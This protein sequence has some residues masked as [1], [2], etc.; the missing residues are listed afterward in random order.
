MVTLSPGEAIDGNGRPIIVG[1]PYHFCFNDLITAHKAR[2]MVV[3]VATH[4]FMPCICVNPDPTAPRDPGAAIRPGPYLLCIE[5]EETP[6]GEAARYG[7]LCGHERA[8]H[9]EA[10]GWRGGFGLSLA[11]FPVALPGAEEIRT[12]WDLRGVLSA[13]YYNVFEH[14]LIKRWD[15]P[16]AVD[17]GFCDPTGPMEHVSGCVPLAMV[18]V[19]HDGSLV[20]LDSWIPR[21]PLAATAAQSSS[22]VTIGAPADAACFARIHQFQCMLAQ[23]LRVA[24]V[25]VTPP[26]KPLYFNLYDRG[27]RNIPPVGFLPVQPI[28][29]RQ[30]RE[31]ADSHDA[32][33]ALSGLMTA[34]PHAALVFGTIL[35]ADRYFKGTTVF[36][37]YVVAL[38][39]DDILEDVGNAFAKDPIVVRSLRKTWIDRISVEVVAD[40]AEAAGAAAPAESSDMGARYVEVV[41]AMNI[42]SAYSPFTVFVRLLGSKVWALV[43]H[44]DAIINRQLEVVKVIVPLQGVRRP[45]PVVGETETDAMTSLRE[46]AANTFGIDLGTVSSEELAREASYS[47]PRHFVCYVKQRVVLLDVLYLMLSLLTLTRRRVPMA[48]A[49]IDKVMAMQP[50]ESEE[51][52]DFALVRKALR[53]TSSEDRAMIAAAASLP[54]VRR[55]LTEAVHLAAPGIAR[56]GV[57]ERFRGRIDERAKELEAAGTASEAAR[58]RAVEEI[59][60]AYALEVPAFEPIAALALVLD[61]DSMDAMLRDVQTIST[62]DIAVAV[63]TGD[64][65]IADLELEKVAPAVFTDDR[66]KLF[67]ASLRSGLTGRKAADFVP[68]LESDITVGRVL[69]L[70]E[71]KAVDLLGGKDKLAAFLRK[72]RP[73]LKAVRTGAADLASL[74]PSDA[75]KERYTALVEAGSKPS[76]AFDAVMAEFATSTEDGKLIGTLKSALKATGE[77]DRTGLAG[78]LFRAGK[79]RPRVP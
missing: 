45:H 6:Q 17:N 49:T 41:R 60:E 21:R 12:E 67:Y 40:T 23:S 24:P 33:G 26:A 66:G 58:T 56:E 19:A 14:N 53:E 59:S 39:D 77:G 79:F 73:A 4:R 76:D 32:I 8:I 15:K 11:Y 52:V 55:V 29:V 31:G 64:Q 34:S 50:L 68:G 5:P 42:S 3:G 20:F 65:S 35:A 38:H 27:F 63:P 2:P 51:P 7:E 37:Y 46:L 30:I 16:F 78:V 69:E 54:E 70:P 25:D 43:T 36:P 10:D 48:Y 61:G 28:D 18:Y 22:R 13:Y 57:L 44:M 71:K 9:C 75:M 1:A 72:T 47:F 62:R 74:E